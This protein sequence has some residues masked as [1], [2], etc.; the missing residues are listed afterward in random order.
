MLQFCC[1]S[2]VLL[3]LYLISFSVVRNDFCYDERF[4]ELNVLLYTSVMLICRS[5]FLSIVDTRSSQVRVSDKLVLDKGTRKGE[6][7]GTLFMK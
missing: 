4:A 7:N 5:M 1:D 3:A 6:S 2:S